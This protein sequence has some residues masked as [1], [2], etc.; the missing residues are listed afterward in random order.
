MIII[1][2]ERRNGGAALNR[3]TRRATRDFIHNRRHQTW[4][5][6]VLQR[7]LLSSKTTQLLCEPA[8]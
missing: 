7:A 4:R 2:S 1:R 3:V 5:R 8:Q 6:F